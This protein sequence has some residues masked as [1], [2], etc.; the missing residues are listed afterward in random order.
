MIYVTIVY[1]SKRTGYW[2]TEDK[3]FKTKEKALKGIF[4]MR[5]KGII[6]DGY[7]CD[8]P[9]DSQWLDRRIAL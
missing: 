7:R 6:I 2:M 8:D 5:G 9:F 1:Q 4:A 3:V